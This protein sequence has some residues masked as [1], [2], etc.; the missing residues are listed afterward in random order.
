MFNIEKINLQNNF[1]RDKVD[2]FLKKFD[3]KLDSNIDFTII[4]RDN[5]TGEIIST[6]SK[7]KNIIKCFAIEKRLQGEGITNQLVT[8]LLNKSFDEGFLHN[9]IFTKPSNIDIFKGVGFKLISKTDKVALLEIGTP[10]IEKKLSE[11]SK[12]FNH[13]DSKNG[14]IIMNCN[15]FTLGHLYLIKESAKKVDNLLVLIVEEDS[16]IFPFRDRIE[17]V[18]KGTSDIDNVTVL[19]S[20]EYIIS[21]KTFPNY[22]LK[23]DDDS[24]TEYMKLDCTITAEWFCKFFNIST[25]FVGDEP[26]CP[27]TKKYNDTMKEIFPKYNINI[28]IIPRINND[29]SIISASKVRDLISK[30]DFTNLYLYLP[31]VTLEYLESDR[32]KK[33]IERL[34]NEI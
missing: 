14:I 19:G 5:E 6:A 31:K 20:S 26:L 17:L 9:F 11:I 23:K 34:Q 25:R 18:K 2:T 10:N 4:I 15:P 28:D 8:T 3:L 21:S 12:E 27:I 16:S 13:Q 22:F 30:N 1:F 32:G 7:F 33:I 24:N 29:I